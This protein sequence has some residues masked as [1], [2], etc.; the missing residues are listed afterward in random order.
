LGSVRAVPAVLSA[1]GFRFSHPDI[2]AAAT[3]IKASPAR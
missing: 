2:A 1:D 3:W